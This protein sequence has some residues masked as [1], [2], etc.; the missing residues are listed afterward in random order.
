M[1]IKGENEGFIK[2]VVDKK[3]GEVFGVFIVGLYVIDII[4]E[5]LSVKVLEGMIYEFF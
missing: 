4:G 1:L 3:Y 5:F 2:F